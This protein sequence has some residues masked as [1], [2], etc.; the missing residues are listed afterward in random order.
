M[1]SKNLQLPAFLLCGAVVVLSASTSPDALAA[2]VTGSEP[3]AVQPTVPS[4][5]LKAFQAIVDGYKSFF[6]KS[7]KLVYGSAYAKSPNGRVVYVVEYSGK[8]LS[9]DV[10]KTDSLVSPFTAYVQ[11]SLRSMDNGSCG[12]VPGYKNMVGWPDVATALTQAD[13]AQCFKP[14]IAGEEFWDRVRFQ[15][16]YQDD[17]WKLVQIL[18]TKYAKPELAISAAIGVP[19]APGIRL[20]DTEAIVF[21]E[22]WTHTILPSQ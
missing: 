3:K 2:G 18:R 13:S 8:D 22:A 7:E 10:R 6:S 20:A 12:T 4:D 1:P 21:N 15:Y 16:A 5:P 11:L 17:K 9:Y 19:A 14:L